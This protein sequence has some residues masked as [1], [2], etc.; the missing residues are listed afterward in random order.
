MAKI[1]TMPTG[2]TVA[3]VAGVPHFPTKNAMAPKQRQNMLNIRVAPLK[4]L[5]AQVP[6]VKPD[7]PTNSGQI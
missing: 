2:S 7:T 6:K 3:P 4:R 1:G 5:T